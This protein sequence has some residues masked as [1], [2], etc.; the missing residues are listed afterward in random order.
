[1]IV[2][3]SLLVLAL[4]ACAWFVLGIRESREI[5]DA[6]AI[7]Q[8]HAK[9]TAAQAARA[10]SLLDGAARLNPD[11][12]VNILRARTALGR[13]DHSG[14]EKIL[15]GVTRREPKNIQAW[16]WVTK[17][18]ADPRTYFIGLVH[19]GKLERYGK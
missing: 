18:S 9:L 2:R 3:V 8:S 1:M 7:I 17:A 10:D 11:E 5:T 12:Q 6:G 13:G 14:A 15:A 4:L 19:I 16:V